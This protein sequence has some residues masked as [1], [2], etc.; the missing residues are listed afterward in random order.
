MSIFDHVA[1]VMAANARQARTIGRLTRLCD[2]QRREIEK[3]RRQYRE[4]LADMEVVALMVAKPDRPLAKDMVRQRRQI[5]GLD[6]KQE[7][8]G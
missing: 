4:L 3:L 7:V 1:P 2:R 6:E 8:G 5:A